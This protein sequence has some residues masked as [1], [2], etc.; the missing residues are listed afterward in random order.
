M[1]D[2]AGWQLLMTSQGCFTGLTALQVRG[3]A[4]PPLPADSPVFMALGKRDPR[5]Q[6]SGVVTSRHVRPVIHDEI[7]GLRV[8]TLPESLVA[9]ARWMGLVDVVVMIDSALHQG[10]VSLAE[11]GTMAGSRRPGA[12][13]LKRALDHVDGR[14]ESPFE[15]L[16]RLL[17]RSCG[18]EVEP[19]WVLRDGAGVEVARADLRVCGTTSLH[20]YDGD[21][22]EE[23]SRRVRDRRRDRRVDRAGYVRRGYTSGDVLHRAVTI[24]EDADRALGR[25]HDPA[26]I[27]SWH[28]LL[29][30]SLFT[31]AGTTRFLERL[32]RPSRRR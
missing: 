25:P 11:L 19:Q 23:A 3:I 21:T 15:T 8:A 1:A 16:L 28:S 4:V 10:A 5:P 29:C 6:R 7:E 30:D 2:L 12:T 31:A 26:R 13:A 20:E 27:R 9:A 18:I 24:L 17:H 14:S 32:P 22:H